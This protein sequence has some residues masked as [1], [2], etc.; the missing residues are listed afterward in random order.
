[1]SKLYSRSTYQIWLQEVFAVEDFLML[2]EDKLHLWIIGRNKIL[3]IQYFSKIT[4]NLQKLT[5]TYFR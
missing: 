1:M 3:H 5:V 2:I 4:K